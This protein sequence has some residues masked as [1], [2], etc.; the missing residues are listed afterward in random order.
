MRYKERRV[1]K[2]NKNKYGYVPKALRISS[3]ERK[4]RELLIAS[5]LLN[6]LLQPLLPSFYRTYLKFEQKEHNND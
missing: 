3:S 5:T 2:R 4:K 6:R 1:M